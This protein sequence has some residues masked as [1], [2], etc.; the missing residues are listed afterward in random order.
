MSFTASQSGVSNGSASMTS[1]RATP[2][3]RRNSWDAITPSSTM[4]RLASGQALGA[5][6]GSPAGL[7]PALRLDLP[8]R[9]PSADDSS[10]LIQSRRRMVLGGPAAEAAAASNMQPGLLDGSPRPSP[11]SG[12]ALGGFGASEREGKVLPS[13]TVKDDGLVRITPDTMACLLQGQYDD[14][15]AGYTVV[16][17]R[18]PYEFQGGAV[19][20]AVNLSCPQEV[21]SH[22]LTPGEGM[23][24]TQP[25]PARQTSMVTGKKHV[26]IFHCEFSAKRGPTL[27]R[28]L[29]AADRDRAKVQDYPAC[30]FPE[31][32]ILAGGYSAFFHIH[33]GHCYP[34]AYVPMDDPRFIQQRDAHMD[35]FRRNIPGP[36]LRGKQLR[37]MP[38][39]SEGSDGSPL[40]PQLR[41]R[42]GM[43]A[44][45]A[46]SIA[47]LASRG[48]FGLAASM[49]RPGLATVDSPGPD[50]S[51][52]G[53]SPLGRSPLLLR[54]RA[55]QGTDTS[56]LAPQ[57]HRRSLAF[58]P[59]A[60]PPPAPS[61]MPGSMPTAMPSAVPSAIGP[62]MPPSMPPAPAQEPT[63]IS[64]G[65]AMPDHYAR[66]SSR[67]F[68][69]P[70]L[71]TALDLPRSLGTGSGGRSSLRGRSRPPTCVPQA[72]QGGTL[73]PPFGQ[74]PRRLLRTG[75]APSLR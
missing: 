51:P 52:L 31:L 20:G 72:S 10:P 48:A 32:Y 65:G 70:A 74:R 23:H 39:A 34:Q 56:P 55:P 38:Q 69:H 8:P 6:D 30:H 1:I 66:R 71:E 26:L 5:I 28:A 33:P 11:S 68:A 57:T 22:L 18:F 47:P 2:G 75:T 27:A 64:L 58:R 41:P 62:S 46:S 17:C 12:G 21:L 35:L 19:K 15:I 36:G 16:D 59:L 54:P 49:A 42:R 60:M 29:R 7:G 67:G 45:A 40:A 61:A 37:P 43:H 9:T 53:D 73:S 63:E 3:R 24:A 50:E 44:R 14:Q 13:Y 4:D 25:L